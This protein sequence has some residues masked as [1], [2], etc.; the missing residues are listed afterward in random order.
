MISRH[1]FANSL[2]TASTASTATGR[3]VRPRS[4]SRIPPPS[5][6]GPLVL[7]SAW[8][9]ARVKIERVCSL[10]MELRQCLDLPALIALFG[11][12]CGI[13]R[14]QVDPWALTAH[15]RPM[16]MRAVALRIEDARGDQRAGPIA[17]LGFGAADRIVAGEQGEGHGH[18]LRASHPPNRAPTI[19][20]TSHAN[21]KSTKPRP[22]MLPSELR[23]KRAAITR[24][25]AC[26]PALR[27]T[28]RGPN[29]QARWPQTSH[30][31]RRSGH[32]AQDAP[33]R[34]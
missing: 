24:H 26:R 3:L 15:V 21:R 17:R 2:T 22:L 19:V 25:L 5:P 23:S 16:A 32:P 31:V 28:R 10:P 33:T 20:G 30:A 34:R 18:S 29:S 4:S 12:R 13:G 27:R 7:A 1:S 6:V 8:L 14:R 9:A 11:E